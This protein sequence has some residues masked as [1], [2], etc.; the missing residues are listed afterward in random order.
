MRLGNALFTGVHNLPVGGRQRQSTLT[1]NYLVPFRVT[2]SGYQ[3]PP[4]L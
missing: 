4:C 3:E 2:L 1:L